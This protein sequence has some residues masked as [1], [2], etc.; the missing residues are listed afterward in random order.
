MS[1]H[2]SFTH[3]LLF[4]LECYPKI[5]WVWVWYGIV[6]CFFVPLLK[7]MLIGCWLWLRFWLSSSTGVDGRGRCEFG[8]FSSFVFCNSLRSHYLQKQRAWRSLCDVVQWMKK[9]KQPAMRGQHVRSCGL[10][11]E[12]LVLLVVVTAFSFRMSDPAGA[13]AAYCYYY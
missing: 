1:H 8:L 13:T 2:T 3:L 7:I 9:K 6:S 10:G 11:R 4:V 5:L 12:F